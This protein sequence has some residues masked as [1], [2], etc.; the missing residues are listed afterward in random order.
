VQPFIAAG[1]DTSVKILPNSFITWVS[2]AA[3]YTGH[4]KSSLLLFRPPH[5]RGIRTKQELPQRERGSERSMNCS[6]S[7]LEQQTHI[8]TK[9]ISRKR[10]YVY[11]LIH[12]KMYKKQIWVWKSTPNSTLKLKPQ[13]GLRYNTESVLYR[14]IAMK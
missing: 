11:I 14:L 10:N 2:K 8:S 9:P 13:W 4:S 1:L 5:E 12:M 6:Y 7:S 3:S